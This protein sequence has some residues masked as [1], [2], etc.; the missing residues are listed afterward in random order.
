MTISPA[1]LDEIKARNPCDQ[2]AGQWVTLRRRG[3]RMVGPCPM[4][5]AGDSTRAT[6][7]EAWPDKW[8]C[9]VCQDGGDVFRLLARY[10]RLDESREFPRIVD[11]LGGTA[12]IDA[13][14]AAR[15]AAERAR[16][17]AEKARQAQRYRERE[18]LR[19]EKIW[20]D[21]LPIAGTAAEAYLRRRG[22]VAPGNARL[23]FLPSFPYFADGREIEPRVLHE[24]PVMVAAIIGPGVE[25]GEFRFAGLHLTYLDLS[26]PKGKAEIV[27]PDSGE[28]MPAKKVRGSKQGGFIEL[29]GA[30]SALSPRRMFA[31]EGIETVLA[32]YTALDRAGAVGPSTRFRCGID[33]GNLAG[34]ALNTVEHPTAKDAGGRARRVPSEI[35]DMASPAMP[36]P[37]SVIDLV[38]LGDGDS[39]AFVTGK[40]MAR[41][42]QRHSA[43]SISGAPQGAAD[44]PLSRTVR[45]LFAPAGR[46]FNDMVMP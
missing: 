25:P 40:A 11:M 7:F 36:V 42:A 27:D 8:V 23:G 2:V 46:D 3:R 30:G 44:P 35:P 20:R 9:A 10:H 4:C 43:P 29:G 14:A 1:V 32:L 15:A 37:A 16:V 17:A 34:R 45:V 24:G 26:K 19:L 38:L 31:G 39:D 21:A 33:L 13:E 18:R 12:S 5:S 22:L 6:R 41:A 28:L